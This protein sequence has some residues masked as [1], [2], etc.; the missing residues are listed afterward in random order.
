MSQESS[1]VP[2]PQTV[3][4]QTAEI[5]GK[6]PSL[7]QD[8]PVE[9]V[10]DVV[11]ITVAPIVKFTADVERE[12]TFTV[13]ALYAINRDIGIGLKELVVAAQQVRIDIM[14]DFVKAGVVFVDPKMK[15]FDAPGLLPPQT[16]MPAFGVL[17]N[18][19]AEAM[20]QFM[21]DAP[22]NSRTPEETS[23]G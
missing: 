17:F 12:I 7:G 8:S 3:A 5:A 20:G 11:P 21:S 18:G 16:I 23:T 6:A 19:F 2:A 22:G 1:G 13:G 9:A 10:A 15:D 4:A 14:M